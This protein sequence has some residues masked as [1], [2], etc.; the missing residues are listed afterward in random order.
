MQAIEASAGAWVDRSFDGEE[1]VERLRSGR[2][3]DHVADRLDAR[4]AR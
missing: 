4:D 1:Y 3:L 2:R